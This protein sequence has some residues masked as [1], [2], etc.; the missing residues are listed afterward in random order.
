[1]QADASIDSDGAKQAAELPRTSCGNLGDTLGYEQERLF[2]YRVS[3]PQSNGCDESWQGQDQFVCD[4]FLNNSTHESSWRIL[5]LYGENQ[6]RLPTV[7]GDEEECDLCLAYAFNGE[8]P[9]PLQSVESLDGHW[10]LTTVTKGYPIY[11][12]E[13]YQG[14][15]DFT[16]CF[17]WDGS[18]DPFELAGLW[19]SRV[20]C[21]L[22]PAFHGVLEQYKGIPSI[23]INTDAEGF[24]EEHLQVA[25][26]LDGSS[27]SLF[28]GKQLTNHDYVLKT[29]IADIVEPQESPVELKGEWTLLTWLGSIPKPMGHYRL[30]PRDSGGLIIDGELIACEDALGCAQ[31]IVVSKVPLDD[32]GGYTLD[33]DLDNV[34]IRWWIDE[35]MMIEGETS[36]RTTSSL[37]LSWGFIAYCRQAIQLQDQS[38]ASLTLSACLTP[39]PVVTSNQHAL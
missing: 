9:Q 14:R 26:R 17:A 3:K 8:H 10:R 34:P 2:C 36:F 20:Q 27:L 13:T 6:E 30:T 22:E 21:A 31:N 4:A 25:S 37:I 28:G 5:N 18:F 33:V 12:I 19:P 7:I 38:G 39:T 15:I 1:M 23:A 11:K 16:A 24:S 35:S 29:V 32:A